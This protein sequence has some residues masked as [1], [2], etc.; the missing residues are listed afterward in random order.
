MARAAQHGQYPVLSF[1]RKRHFW[2]NRTVDLHL[3]MSDDRLDHALLLELLDG[4][5]SERAVDLHS[6]DQDGNGDEAVGLDILVQLLSGGLVEQDGVLGLV[7]DLALGPLLLLLLCSSSRR[8][9]KIQSISISAWRR[10]FHHGP[11]AA[12]DG[13]DGGG[14]GGHTILSVDVA[15]LVDG[16][17][18]EEL[19]FL[20]TT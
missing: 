5:A 8:L 17:V 15:W 6:V 12:G 11:A 4:L 2:C 13:G 14:G 1:V 3:A 16:R 20:A 19:E 7:L 18:V 10:A 9:S